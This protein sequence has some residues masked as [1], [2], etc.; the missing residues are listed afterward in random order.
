M[1]SEDYLLLAIHV[2]LA[3]LLGLVAALLTSLAGAP[4]V[5]AAICAVAAGTGF[6]IWFRRIEAA[7][8][9]IH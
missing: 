4:F 1:A 7:T 2:Y 9:R 6:L 5:G 8:P 3:A